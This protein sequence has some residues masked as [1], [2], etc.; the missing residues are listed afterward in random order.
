MS[1]AIL[2]RI[3]WASRPVS[4]VNTAFPFAAAYFLTTH[5]VSWT[6][7]LGSIFFL[8]PYNLLMYGVNDVFDY[9]SDIVNPRKGGIE[10]AKH[11]K[12]QLNLIF[13]AAIAVGLPATLGMFIL[14]TLTAKLVLAGIMFLVLAYSLPKLRFKERPFID[15]IT[16]S[17][18]FTGP[19]LYA[20]V[21]SGWHA[22]YLPY[23]V[24]FF[25]WG[26][27]SHAFGAV[28]DIIPDRKAAIS[29]I[30]TVL[31]AASTVQFAA[32]LYLSV[33][34]VLLPVGIGAGIVGACSLLYVV[35]ISP[36]LRVIDNDSAR[37]NKAWKRFIWL[38]LL[39]GFI[40]TL[41]LIQAARTTN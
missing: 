30:A 26:M 20:F 14:G 7:V 11:T 2:K 39:T 29:S 23:L 16:S 1:T 18:H 24:A 9:E 8:I 33:F 12:D 38:N 27:A 17:C 37:A 13:Y 28:Q 6:L 34:L 32:I 31:G 15:S 19:M 21:L 40:V 3:F 4:W 36:Y 35:N 22:S 25:A 41:V 10:G 5:E